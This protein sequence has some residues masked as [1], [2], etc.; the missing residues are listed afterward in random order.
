MTTSFE[1]LTTTALIALA[2]AVGSAL[3]GYP[4]GNWL[5][6]LGTG[7]RSVI[8]PV[9]LLPFL[10]PAFLVGVSLL[11]LQGGDIDSNSGI[12]WIVA[13]HMLMNI[14]F[15]ARVTA[16]LVV[17][18]EQLEAA[19]LDRAS[20]LKSRL[21]I[22]L[23][24]QLPGISAAGLLVALYSATS[25]GLVLSLGRGRVET[26]E[27]EVAY[28]ALRELDLFG[29]GLLAL[30]QTILT[31]TMFLIASRLG[32][33][34]TPL[35]GAEQSRGSW[36]GL[37]L[38]MLLLASTGYLIWSIASRAFTLNGGILNNLVALGS[39]GSR[40]ILNVS[41]L[42]A[43]GNSLR[44]MIIAVLIAFPVA[45]LA[46]GSKKPR[47]IWL[48]PIGISPVVIGLSFLVGSGYLPQALVGW[49]LL[50]L[51]QSIFLIPLGYQILRPARGA[52]EPELLESAILDGASRT[53]IFSLVELPILARPIATALAFS[54]LGALG[55][56]G[57][58]SFLAYGSQTTLS[59]A[60]FRLASR[61]GAENLG[62][63]MTAALL[64]V[65]LALLIVFL[66]AREPGKES[67]STSSDR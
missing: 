32:A 31:L 61:P 18:K 66:I 64:F 5:A 3:L 17:P 11:P 60:I 15:M 14:G 63:A 13:A 29:A 28:L 36:L 39:Q 24:Q 21:F 30:L 7:I 12:L 67:A 41:V 42:E 40:D 16:S 37:G 50:P 62:M 43:A 46:A 44:N 59:L 20:R 49:W 33:T 8:S 47:V 1:L 57:A 51:A 56:F 26:L 38:G 25:F 22:E 58:A 52:V 23:P 2:S 55:E 35:F 34:P 4:I 65:L 27:T 48:L 9:L 53:A 6:S 45:W 19:E 10:L 54:A